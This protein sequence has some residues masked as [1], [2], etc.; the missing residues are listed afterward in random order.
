MLAYIHSRYTK[1]PNYGG[2]ITGFN[3]VATHI[4]KLAELKE[5]K[6]ALQEK[7]DEIRQKLTWEISS[8]IVDAQDFD[9]IEFDIIVGGM[10]DVIEKARQKDKITEAWKLSGAKFRQQKKKKRDPKKDSPSPKKDEKN[11]N[12][13][14]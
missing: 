11:K 13:D 14:Q 12:D 6:Q 10:L 2:K 4:K 8:F 5:K 9:H 3:M 7:E 1:S